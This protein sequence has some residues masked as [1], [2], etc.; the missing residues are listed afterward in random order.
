MIM[1]I[2]LV[3]WYHYPIHA[4]SQDPPAN[5]FIDYHHRSLLPVTLIDLC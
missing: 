1:L 2:D 5:F 4:I 3:E